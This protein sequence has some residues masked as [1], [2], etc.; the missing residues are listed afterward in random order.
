MPSLLRILPNLKPKQ[1][2][3]GQPPAADMGDS[4]L[5]LSRPPVEPRLVRAPAIRRREAA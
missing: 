5:D 4:G 3:R 1:R 2:S